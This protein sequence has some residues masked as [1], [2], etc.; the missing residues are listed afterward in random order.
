MDN[1][2]I[3]FIIVTWNN[4]KQIE[5]CLETLTRYTTVPH[6]IIIVDNVSR[7]RTCDIIAQKYPLVQ[8][9]KSKENLGF[10]RGNNFALKK[11]RTPYVC[12]I[13]PDVILT[14]DITLPA[15]NILNQ[16]ENVGLVTNK[17]CNS[18]GSNQ[19]TTGRFTDL[20]S[21]LISVCHFS[22]F[23][24][25]P[26]RKNLCPE[27]YKIKNGVFFPDWVIGAEM[28]MRTSDAKKIGGFSID[29]YMYI[30]DMDIC[31]K[32]RHQLNKKVLY[33]ADISMIHLGGASEKQ[34]QSY[35]KQ[36][37]LYVNTFLF[38]KKYYGM[39]KT[40]R[41]YRFIVNLYKF[42]KML[43]YPLKLVNPKSYIIEHNRNVLKI[44]TRLDCSDDLGE[45]Y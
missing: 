29:Y 3:T 45:K 12:F 5:T 31:W 21:I 13:N 32:V 18:D 8:L 1:G 10:A 43:I 40:Y 16:Y 15:I 4:E 20:V 33:N 34:N 19:L 30:E 23:I 25:N 24:P 41:L 44:L 6:E 39:K 22:L 17:L 14:E 9:I 11:V 7:D 35:S 28:F 38:C 37:K 2:L 26:L 42:R 36:E 27:Y